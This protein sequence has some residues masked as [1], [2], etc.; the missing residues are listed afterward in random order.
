MLT[1]A[2]PGCQMSR[3][4][5][6]FQTMANS[7]DLLVS[8]QRAAGALPVIVAIALSD[9]SRISSA[10]SF[11]RAKYVPLAFTAIPCHGPAV[12]WRK[13]CPLASKTSMPPASF[14]TQA[15]PEE[16]VFSTL[17]VPSWS[18]LVDVPFSARN[19]AL[20]SEFEVRTGH[21]LFLWSMVET[22]IR[23]EAGRTER[24]SWALDLHKRSSKIDSVS[25]STGLIRPRNRVH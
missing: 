22:P 6:A 7:G 11:Q 19:S 2:R 25:S 5:S 4:F 14:S 21:L 17:A 12:V 16:S 23:D 8:A 18:S 3:R 10:L 9:S 24:P 15:R 1:S 20:P 13:H